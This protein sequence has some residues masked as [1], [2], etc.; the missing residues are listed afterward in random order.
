MRLCSQIKSTFVRADDRDE[1]VLLQNEGWL[2]EVSAGSVF[3]LHLMS[4]QAEG[5]LI[6]FT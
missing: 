5:T 2:S 1:A 3:K 4:L 6:R